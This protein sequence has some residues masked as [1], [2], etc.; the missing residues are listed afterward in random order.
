MTL[1]LSRESVAAAYDF[2]RTTLPFSNWNLPESEDVGFEIDNARWT[3]AWYKTVG[4]GKKRKH[5]I[6]VSNRC[7]GFV[8]TLMPHLAHEM[9][10]LHMA[11]TGMSRGAGDH[12]K[13]FKKLADEVCKY[14]GF[15]S[16]FF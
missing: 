10:H 12:G 8:S 7:V 11:H 1:A 5:V 9:V 14:H 4:R 13:A 3:V 6:G 16:K 15:D 2:L